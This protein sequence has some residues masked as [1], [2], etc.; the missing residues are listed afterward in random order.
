LYDLLEENERIDMKNLMELDFWEY[1][2]LILKRMRHGGLLCTV[3]DKDSRNN[4]ITLGWGQI[5]PFYHDHPVFIIAVSPMR[6]SWQFLEDIPEFVIA[7]PDES[8]N[9]AA[10]ICGSVSGRDV[11][12]FRS[13]GLTQVKSRYV[14]APSILEAPINIECRIYNKIGPPHFI[15]SPEHRK[16]PLECQHTIYFA[17]VLGTFGRKESQR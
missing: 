13:A 16:A 3:T 11:D 6:Y 1:P 5:G 15:L 9:D 2:T 10:K 7:V 8:L 14:K 4:I 17:E 12:K